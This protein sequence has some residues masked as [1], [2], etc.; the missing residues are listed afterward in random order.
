MRAGTLSQGS[1]GALDG[2][3]LTWAS[4]TEQPGG[5]TSP[6]E[7]A[8]AALP[9]PDA[10]GPTHVVRAARSAML[11]F[12]DPFFRMR[13]VYTSA[14]CVNSRLPLCALTRAIVRSEHAID[15]SDPLPPDSV[16]TF[17][18]EISQCQCVS[19]G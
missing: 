4:R 3:Q 11:I 8:A 7:L 18:I 15:G 6:E 2:L 14:P 9:S 17:S 16:A 5:K 13:G 1:S 19:T 12:L 10:S